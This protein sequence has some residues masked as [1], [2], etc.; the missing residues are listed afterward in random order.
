ML[1]QKL[2]A[3]PQFH[4][5]CNGF[6]CVSPSESVQSAMNTALQRLV[7]PKN[8]QDQPSLS[9]VEDPQADANEEVPDGGSNSSVPPPGLH[10]SS[11]ARSRYG[12][13]DGLTKH[14]L[15]VHVPRSGAIG[16]SKPP[17]FLNAIGR[18]ECTKCQSMHS[19]R[20]PC[21]RANK[22]YA[23]P[24]PPPRTRH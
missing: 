8:A 4:C 5:R 23:V 3:H 10:R 7:I 14:L 22:P 15:Q 9:M 1:F 6:A 16:L 21:P 12:P 19:L 13:V 20:S 2:P 11:A 18:W 17:A 24:A